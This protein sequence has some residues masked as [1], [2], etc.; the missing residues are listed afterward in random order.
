MK[1]LIK[2]WLKMPLQVVSAQIEMLAEAYGE[3]YRNKLCTSIFE[4]YHTA[5]LN[6]N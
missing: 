6:E 5:V 2:V 4:I 1:K 3:E